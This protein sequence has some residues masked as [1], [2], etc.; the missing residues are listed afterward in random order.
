MMDTFNEPRGNWAGVSANGHAQVARGSTKAV[1]RVIDWPAQQEAALCKSIAEGLD[2]DQIA[3][4]FGRTRKSIS[5]KRIRMGL[6]KDKARHA[7]PV[8]ADFAER[9]RDT[10][11]SDLS[12]HY[13]RSLKTIW[14]W[15]QEAG[16]R[17]PPRKASPPAP[18]I[19]RKINFGPKPAPITIPDSQAHRA[20]RHLMRLYRPVCRATTI[21]PKA[22]KDL[23]IVG[24]NKMTSGDMIGLAEEKGFVAR[25]AA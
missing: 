22:S 9:A 13:G 3:E 1:R 18:R 11:S 2:D 21:D 20:A 4:R 7:L 19:T 5:S 17:P 6:L 24:R 8:P 23:W 14:K 10:S 15:R 25:W 12:V 16:V